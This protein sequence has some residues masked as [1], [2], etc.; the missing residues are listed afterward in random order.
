M[1]H[2]SRAPIAPIRLVEIGDAARSLGVTA[3]ALRHY[4]DRGLVRS[5]RLARNVRGYDFG[6]LEQ[7]KAIVALRAVGLPVAAIRTLLSLR[8]E[9]EAQ[10]RALRAALI[11]ALDQ[12]KAQ[13]Q[14][15]AALAERLDEDGD[16]GLPA[17]IAGL[18]SG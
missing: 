6:A 12:Q 11:E 17:A 4:E 8:S 3:R 9:P 7:L 5:H 15:L 14:R 2:L 10:T 18:R 1:N 13:L 16:S